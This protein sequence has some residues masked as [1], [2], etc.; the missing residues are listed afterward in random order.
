MRSLYECG[1]ARVTTNG[2]SIHCREEG[3]KPL[4]IS[5]LAQGGLLELEACQDCDGF[6]KIGPPIPDGER[7]WDDIPMLKKPVDTAKKIR[8]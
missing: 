6:K 5:F 7:G 4:P 8:L 1:N 3:F 2:M